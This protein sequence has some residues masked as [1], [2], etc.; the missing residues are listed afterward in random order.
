[1]KKKITTL[2]TYYY[3]EKYFKDLILSIRKNIILLKE[4]INSDIIIVNDS[5]NFE[6]EKKIENIIQ[7]T[8]IE[9]I[10][11]VI[12]INNETNMG[13]TASRY[14]GMLNVKSDYLHI[15]DQD[16]YIKA[17]TY[18][19]FL[20]LPAQKSIGVGVFDGYKIKNGKILEKII[21]KHPFSSTNLNNPQ[22]NVYGVNKIISVGMC[23]YSYPHINKLL[24]IYNYM[25]KY[26][27]LFDGIDD[28]VTYYYLL[29]NGIYFNYINKFNYYYRLHGQNQR[30]RKQEKLKVIQGYK[31]IKEHFS[32]EIPSDFFVLREVLSDLLNKKYFSIVKNFDVFAK[33]LFYKFF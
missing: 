22:R 10:A 16:D 8:K 1:M 23:I 9:K 18:S 28:G 31:L 32:L 12:L 14:I 2:I 29:K 27:N 13:V 3:G 24:E 26:G 5:A 17:S 33:Y 19:D 15:I 4:S 21:K 30:N 20:S 11:K 7:E 25:V 6:E